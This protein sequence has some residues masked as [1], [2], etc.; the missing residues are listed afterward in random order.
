MIHMPVVSPPAAHEWDTHIEYLF[1]M[2]VYFGHMWHELWE[3]TD[4]EFGI[5]AYPFILFQ[6]LETEKYAPYWQCMLKKPSKLCAKIAIEKGLVPSFESFIA[7]IDT[8]MADGYKSTC[9]LGYRRPKLIG[10]DT[11]ED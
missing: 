1:A 11:K 3:S 2:T 10:S 8:L 4:E 7:E 6:F 9:S 5:N